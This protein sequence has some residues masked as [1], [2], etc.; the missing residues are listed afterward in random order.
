METYLTEGKTRMAALWA[1]DDTEMAMQ[2]YANWEEYLMNVPL[3]VAILG[4]LV[5]VS[6]TS[7]FS[8]DPP[9]GGFKYIKYPDSFHACLMQ[10]ANSGWTAFSEAHKNMEQIHLQVAKLPVYIEKA[11]SQISEEPLQNPP[12]EQKENAATIS[13]DCIKLARLTQQNITQ[14]KNLTEE[15]L[16]AS[17]RAKREH[18]PQMVQSSLEESVQEAVSYV[19][20]NELGKILFEDMDKWISNAENIIQRAA[21]LHQEEPVMRLMCAAAPVVEKESEDLSSVCNVYSKARPLV[22]L[23]ETLSDFVDEKEIKWSDITDQKQGQAKI[24]YLVEQCEQIKTSV[25]SEE[26]CNE[27]STAIDICKEAMDLCSEVSM[28]G[29][30]LKGKCEDSKTEEIMARIQALLTRAQK[31]DLDRQALQESINLAPQLLQHVECSGKVTA[32][33]MLKEN[34]RLRIEQSRVQLNKVRH[35]QQQSLENLEKN[36][37]ELTEILTTTSLDVKDNDFDTMACILSKCQDAMATVKQAWEKM[38][39]SADLMSKN[40]QSCLHVM[41]Q[42]LTKDMSSSRKMLIKDAIYQ[43]AFYASNVASMISTI[44]GTYVEVSEKHL[45]DTI[46]SLGKLMALDPVSPDFLNERQKIRNAC[47]TALSSITD[48]VKTTNEQSYQMA[49]DKLNLIE[50]EMKSLSAPKSEENIKKIR[51]I[52]EAVFMSEADK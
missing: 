12:S 47:K 14:V 35:L 24:S 41:P 16:E 49:E 15:L 33:K 25:E 6:P 44:S 31:F 43:Q 22:R 19:I 10:V 48:H 26:D 13:E 40:I 34:I 50:S 30:D 46:S 36:Q 29:G 8:I 38:V 21:E 9:E 3:A 7:D 5:S 17:I 45:M 28:I 37:K 20:K 18:A 2:P 52:I 42:E 4:E 39:D 1:G 23:A 32:G 27:K 51:E 11:V